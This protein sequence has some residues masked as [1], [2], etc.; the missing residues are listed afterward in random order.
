MVAREKTIQAKKTEL[1]EDGYLIWKMGRVTY[2]FYLGDIDY[3]SRRTEYGVEGTNIIDELLTLV[4]VLS[5]HG[6]GCND[7]LSEE[8]YRDIDIKDDDLDSTGVTYLE[9]DRPN[10]SFEELISLSEF[11]RFINEWS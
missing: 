8:H 7:I 3:E 10:F 11:E 4:F 2:H 9:R 1:K 5:A 6:K